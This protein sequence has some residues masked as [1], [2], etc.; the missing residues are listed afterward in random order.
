MSKM[1]DFME[2]STHTMLVVQKNVE[3]LETQIKQ[4]TQELRELREKCNSITTRSGV[5][6][7]KGIGDNIQSKERDIESEE[8]RKS[9]ERKILREEKKEEEEKNQK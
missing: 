1:E 7:G 5:V 4:L 2:K 6:I 9:K 3:N 8:E